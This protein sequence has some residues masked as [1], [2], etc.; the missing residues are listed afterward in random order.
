[1][2][3]IQ[4]IFAHIC[5]IFVLY[6]VVVLFHVVFLYFIKSFSLSVA[7]SSFICFGIFLV[8]LYR[9]KF[10]RSWAT[11]NDSLPCN[12]P[13]FISKLSEFNQV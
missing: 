11:R 1:M 6:F 2:K 10:S 3:L 13:V 9:G 7:A 8:R 12:L 5:C 4:I